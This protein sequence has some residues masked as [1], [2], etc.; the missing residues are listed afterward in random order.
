MIESVGGRATLGSPARYRSGFC[1]S[2]PRP[3]P[4]TKLSPGRGHR[5]QGD[6]L[7]VRS[8]INLRVLL[9]RLMV[10]DTV[11]MLYTPPLFFAV[12][13]D[14]TTT[15]E[16]SAAPPSDGVYNR[17][18]NLLGGSVSVGRNSKVPIPGAT[19]QRQK[20]RRQ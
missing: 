3:P 12:F 20:G 16:G 11:G 10:S 15:K 4:T 17:R 8:T 7:Q 13:N 5:K 1:L 19:A 9:S 14:E 2:E 18:G 6:R